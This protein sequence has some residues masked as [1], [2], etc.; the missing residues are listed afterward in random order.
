MTRRPEGEAGKDASIAGI[1]A[2]MLLRL[3]DLVTY[4][5]ADRRSGRCSQ[6]AAADV[7]HDGKIARYRVHFHAASLDVT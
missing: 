3:G 7:T 4:D 6:N 5:A 1:T 2:S